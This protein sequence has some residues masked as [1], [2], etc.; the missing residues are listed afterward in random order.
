MH[1]IFIGRRYVNCLV[2]M[3]FAKY[4][5]LENIRSQTYVMI[6]VFMMAESATEV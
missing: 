5:K 4:D 1:G 2:I 6:L 3:I